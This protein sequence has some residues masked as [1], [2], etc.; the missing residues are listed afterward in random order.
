MSPL[1]ALI[2]GEFR[3]NALRTASNEGRAGIVTPPGWGFMV[4]NE[5]ATTASFNLPDNVEC[6][7]YIGGGMADNLSGSHG[8]DVL[9]GAAGVDVLSGGAGAD[10]FPYNGGEIGVDQI[11]DFTP[12]TDK[13]ALALPTIDYAG[14][15]RMASTALVQGAGANAA[16]SA[17]STFIYDS[18]TGLLS[19]DADGS[20]VGG[21]I[22]LAT[23][24]PGL[25]LSLTDFIFV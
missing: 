23:L 11:L 15:T 4:D 17:E 18:T 9:V 12:G 14:F 22:A 16:T 3:L 8:N 6:L 1:A 21:L 25:T 20:L 7:V 2:G 19:Y 24:Q 13:I 10:Q 5:E